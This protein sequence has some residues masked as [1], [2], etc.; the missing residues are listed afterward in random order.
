MTK[1]GVSHGW[2]TIGTKNIQLSVCVGYGAPKTGECKP[3]P[4]SLDWGP[5]SDIMGCWKGEYMSVSAL[6]TTM[7]DVGEEL[8]EKK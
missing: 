7:T 3:D 1:V 4:S 2:N 5:S 6:A 8:D